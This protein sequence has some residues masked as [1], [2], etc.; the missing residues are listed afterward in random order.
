[1]VF[2]EITGGHEIEPNSLECCLRL[3]MSIKIKLIVI[4]ETRSPARVMKRKL[5]QLPMGKAHLPPWFL[6]GYIPTGSMRVCGFPQPVRSL[7]SMD[8]R[9]QTGQEPAPPWMLLGAFQL[10]FVFHMKVCRNI[11]LVEQRSQIACFLL[12]P[13]NVIFYIELGL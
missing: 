4:V 13:E 6:D 11:N 1:M 8:D 7:V 5:A 10:I 9:T 12:C 3:H 2:P